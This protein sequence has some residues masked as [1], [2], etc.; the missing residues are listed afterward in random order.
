MAQ[1]TTIARPYAKAVFA[2]AQQARDFDRWQ[3]QL[4]LLAGFARDPQLRAAAANPKHSGAEIARLIVD[5][6]GDK[7][8]AV[9]R[10]LV[11]LL[12][13]RKRLTVLPDILEQYAALR[14]DAEKVVEVELVTAVPADSGVQQRFAKALEA[15]LGRSVQLH[16]STDAALIGGA[17]IKAG[18]MVIDGSVRGRLAA[19]ALELAK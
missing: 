19:L 7:L 13:E 17:L 3:R 8:D 16:N 4:E 18:D 2:V 10:N 9:G 11:A 12:A 15:R 5:A 1:T 14:R 6:A